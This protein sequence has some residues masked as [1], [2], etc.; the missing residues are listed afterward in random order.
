MP[1]SMLPPREQRGSRARCIL[2]T[3]GNDALVAERLTRLAA[4]FAVIDPDRH[5]WMP[6]GASHPAEARLGEAA[7]LLSAAHRQLLTSWWLAVRKRANT[8]NWDIAAAATIEGREGLVLVEAKAHHRELKRDGLGARNA[9]N[10]TQI[11][12]AIHE[13]DGRLNQIS[14]G[15]AL[16]CD[17]H[18]QLANR[19]AWSWKLAS[20]GI[21]VVLMYLGFLNAAEMQDRGEPFATAADWEGAVRS[22]ASAVVPED[23]WERRLEVEGTRFI[24][25]IRAT[26]LP[27]RG[28]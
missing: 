12:A 18:Y 8:P 28:L 1:R 13:A 9:S 16:S 19:F 24:P 15:W 27:L 10:R 26:E 5:G 3:D 7:G 17:S 14:S 11:R 23:A 20:L 21:P 2:L 22:H 6:R 4:P 25:I